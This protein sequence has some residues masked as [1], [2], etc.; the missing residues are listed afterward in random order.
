VPEERNAMQLITAI[1]AMSHAMKMRVVAEG[2][3]REEQAAFLREIG[4]DLAQGWLFARPMRSSELRGTLRRGT[5]RR[6][7]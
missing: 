5:I 7:A 6:I 2:V 3:E 1:V 4:C